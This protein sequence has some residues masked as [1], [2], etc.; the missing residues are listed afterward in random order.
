MSEDSSPGRAYLAI[1]AVF[2]MTVFAANGVLI[3]FALH[4]LPGRGDGKPVRR[5]P[6]VQQT[7]RRRA[8]AG[9]ARLESGRDRPPEGAGER[10]VSTFRDGT[11]RRS[12]TSR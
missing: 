2:F 4:N 1:L 5:E 7:H 10:I 6:G 11:A 9:R 12:K 8:R 3:Y